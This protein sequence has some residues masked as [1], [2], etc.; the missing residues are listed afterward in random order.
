MTLS[1]PHLS[2]CAVSKADLVDLMS[3]TYKHFLV[4]ASAYVS[5]PL[6]LS[7]LANIHT[8]MI[9]ATEGQDKLRKR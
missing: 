1:E 7:E 2:V 4:D 3:T 6:C 8:M 9:V 5:A